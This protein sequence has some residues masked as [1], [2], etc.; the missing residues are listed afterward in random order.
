MKPRFLS[1]SGV[2][3]CLLLFLQVA[4]AMQP[5][6]QPSLSTQLSGSSTNFHRRIYLIRHGATDWNDQGK[7]QGG[8]ADIALNEKGKQQANRMAREL[9]AVGASF[10]L[11]ASSHLQRACQTAD[12]LC[13]LLS[14]ASGSI[15]ERDPG[16]QTF[17]GFREME[18]GEHEGLPIKGP[19]CTR[20]TTEIFNRYKNPMMQGNMDLA[21]P[22][23]ES[24]RQV[25]QR[26]LNTLQE[27]LSNE[28]TSTT[29]GPPKQIAIVGHAIMNRLLLAATL[30]GDGKQFGDFPQ[31]NCCINVIDQLPDGSF[32]AV[33][34]N[35]NQH[36]L[37]D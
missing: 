31:D 37:I 5:Q 7:L 26:A 2:G 25:E 10:D 12:E 3:G 29:I 14:P 33:V 9:Q 24:L 35:Y 8:C 15:P 18:Y 22:G 11:V 32:E 30:R 13:R 16:R 21:W 36:T 6:Q 4:F 1:G 23:G 19:N 20:Q 17:P 34:L 28:T 27:I